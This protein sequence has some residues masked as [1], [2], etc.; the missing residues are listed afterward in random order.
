MKPFIMLFLV[1][2]NLYFI[3]CTYK[4]HTR[5]NEARNE[6]AHLLYAWSSFS[7]AHK[8]M[9]TNETLKDTYSSLTWITS[10]LIILVGYLLYLR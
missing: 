2:T 3:Y 5:V 10:M 7:A 6:Q 1:G 9:Q 4:H 8:K